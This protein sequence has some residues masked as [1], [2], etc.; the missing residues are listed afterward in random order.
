MSDLYLPDQFPS[1]PGMILCI[2]IWT[3]VD[4]AEGAKNLSDIYL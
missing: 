2:L 4:K 3:E 1:M